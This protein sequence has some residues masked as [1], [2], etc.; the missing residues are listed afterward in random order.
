[1]ILGFFFGQNF[2]LVNSNKILLL[3][4]RFVQDVFSGIF[5]LFTLLILYLA[6][7]QIGYCHALFYIIYCLYQLLFYILYIAAIIQNG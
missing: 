4:F 1:M 6:A 7:S 5:E 3:H 2:D